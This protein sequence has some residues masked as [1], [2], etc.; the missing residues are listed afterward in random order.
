MNRLREIIVE[1][2]GKSG[3]ITFCDFMEMALYHPALGYYNSPGEKIGDL[4]DFYTAASVS[5]LFG[6]AIAEEIKGRRSQL[7]ESGL[8]YVAEFGA[9]TGRL[10]VDILNYL[11]KDPDFHRLRYVIVER[12]PNLMSRQAEILRQFR[13]RVIWSDLHELAES[14]IA[15]VFLQNEVIDAFA[16]HRVVIEKGVLKEIYVGYQGE[17]IEITGRPSTPELARYLDK[18]AMPLAEGQQAEINLNALNWLENLSRALDRGFIITIDYGGAA[19]EIYSSMRYQG[20]LVSYFKHQLKDNPY[21]NIGRQDITAHVNFTALIKRG[22]ELGLKTL[23]L[24][25]QANFLISRKIM[26]RLD[27]LQRS[28]VSETEKFKARLAVKNLIMPQ[29]M[30]ERFRVLTQKKDNNGPYI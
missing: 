1:K 23:G 27:E 6:Q 30:G 24:E 26:E 17:F 12:S 15:G 14:P 22:E 16:V 18:Y 11:E 13:G 21:N 2:I 25:T 8:F 29:T 20:T 5:G 7:N 9:G 4:G 3:P 19:G 10:A 28:D